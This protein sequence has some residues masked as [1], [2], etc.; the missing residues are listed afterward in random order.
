LL[1]AGE[2]AWSREIAGKELGLSVFFIFY[3]IRHWGL[4]IQEKIANTNSSSLFLFSKMRVRIL[5]LT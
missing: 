4:L 5:G 2:R 3:W 1:K